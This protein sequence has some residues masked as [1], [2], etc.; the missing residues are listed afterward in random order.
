MQLCEQLGGMRVQGRQPLYVRHRGAWH[1]CCS[2]SACASM[3]VIIDL[4]GV[5]T[6]RTTLHAH[7]RVP[8]SFLDHPP[9]RASSGLAAATVTCHYCRD[10]KMALSDRSIYIPRG[11]RRTTESGRPG[12]NGT[13]RRPT[14][15]GAWTRTRTRPPRPTQVAP[16][17]WPGR[18]LVYVAATRRS[19]MGVAPPRTR[20]ALAAGRVAVARARTR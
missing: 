8:C 10:L 18:A 1:S 6:L 3:E 19:R 20:V 2:G 12:W 13:S 5:N 14:A 4:L 16:A 17:W 9:M 7:E 11:G 15:T